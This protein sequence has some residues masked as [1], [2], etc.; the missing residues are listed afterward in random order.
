MHNTQTSLLI[1]AF[2]L[3][4]SFTGKPQTEIPDSLRFKKISISGENYSQVS[5]KEVTISAPVPANSQVSLLPTSGLA[6]YERLLKMYELEKAKA[7]DQGLCTDEIDSKLIQLNAKIFFEKNKN[8]PGNFSHDI[9]KYIDTGNYEED[10]K[11]YNEA[12]EAWIKSRQ[13]ENRSLIESQQNVN[14]SKIFK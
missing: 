7:A 10:T 13:E 3:L 1:I 11:R 5:S 9:P 12:K 14:E 8:L 2:N 6:A 4:L